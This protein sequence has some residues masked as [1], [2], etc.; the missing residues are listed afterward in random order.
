MSL[1]VKGTIT[2]ILPPTNGTSKTGKE[3]NKQEFVVV[4]EGE[5]GKMVCITLFGDKT[6]LLA[7]FNINDEV[8]V[9]LNIE[10][11]EFN[12]KYYHNINAWRIEKVESS[13]AP[14]YKPVQDNSAPP[15]DDNLPF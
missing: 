11:R 4:Q 7:N 13:A 14:E 6:S 9:S 3:W 1:E 10:S 12:E 15:E 8:K 2:Q 5:F